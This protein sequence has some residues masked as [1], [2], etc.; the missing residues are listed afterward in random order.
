MALTKREDFVMKTLELQIDTI[1]QQIGAAHGEERKQLIS[2]L[3]AAVDK[4][5]KKGGDLSEARRTRLDNLSDEALEAQF[6]NMPI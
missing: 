5:A 3:A 2:K 4:L 1:E 6:D